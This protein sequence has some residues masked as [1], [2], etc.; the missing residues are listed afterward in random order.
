MKKKYY[1]LCLLLILLIIMSGCSKKEEK[2]IYELKSYSSKELQN[3]MFYIKSGEEY[4]PVAEG[5]MLFENRG[6]KIPK[7]VSDERMVWFSDDDCMIPTLYQ[8]DQLVYI[9]DS[10]VPGSFIWERYEDMG[11][12]IGI[13]GLTQNES[14]RYTFI[15]KE[16]NIQPISESYDAF[17]KV[18]N[19]TII[20]VDKL[21]NIIVDETNVSR[22]GTITGLTY[23][24]T[25]SVDVYLGTNY[26][27]INISADTHAF[28]SYELY[29][30]AGYSLSQE[31]YAA[32]VIPEYFKSGYYYING[33]G[34]FKYVA[35][36]RL[37]GIQ[38][39]DF[40]EPYY[41]GYD[42]NGNM[43]TADDI[44][45][46]TGN[47]IEEESFEPIWNSKITL[48]CSQESMTII[49]KYS[50]IINLINGELISL[51]SDNEAEKPSA[52]IMG[53]DGKT[54]SF[55]KDIRQ[56]NAISCTIES[57]LTG[58]WYIEIK[59]MNDRTFDIDT[60]LV[61]GHSDNLVHTG[62][63]QA[64]MTVFLPQNLIDGIFMFNWDNAEHAADIVVE[65][66]TGEKYGKSINQDDLIGEGYG[67]VDIKIPNCVT[68]NYKV[69]V[70]GEDLGRVRFSYKEN[71]TS[72]GSEIDRTGQTQ[73]F[74]DDT[75]N[76]NEFGIVTGTV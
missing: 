68:G 30:T 33:I 31:G 72:P 27:S 19:E 21:D 37:D 34:M 25:Y 8:E 15:K 62:K 64:S 35:N 48:D 16:E 28:S 51:E 20:N 52:V 57:P 61:S 26:E 7:E 40:N 32:I 5:T 14:G 70:S 4:Y 75:E 22:G 53:P 54:Y 71:Y 41:L 50:D 2:P 67:Y 36:S 58:D 10:T 44:D 65:T 45:E 66:P 43:V 49:I 13:R 46:S 42:E 18:N 69:I 23:G 74:P 38:D 3:G 60:A 11:Y 56:E 73:E 55:E 12:T 47:I 1:S 63:G 6:G 17:S 76:E 39:I 59:G 24:K 9:T 29:E